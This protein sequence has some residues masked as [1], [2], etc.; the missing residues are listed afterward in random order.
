M[1][2][3]DV[4]RFKKLAIDISVTEVEDWKKGNRQYDESFRIAKKYWMAEFEKD[5]Y[6]KLFSTENIVV[7]YHA[8]FY[9]DKLNYDL[10]KSLSIYEY[11]LKNSIPVRFAKTDKSNGLDGVNSCIKLIKTKI[12]SFNDVGDAKLFRQ[13]KM[14]GQYCRDYY[15]AL[16]NNKQKSVEKNLY[17]IKNLIHEILLEN[18]QYKFFELEFNQNEQIQKII[19][20]LYYAEI[21]HNIKRSEKILID[22]LNSGSI[23]PKMAQF[24]KSQLEEIKKM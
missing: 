22:I 3:T 15:L 14:Y 7:Q 23:S 8:A 10:F 13:F 16:I 2:E 12:N 9:S 20:A 6:E 17:D 1:L 11:I 19:S 5:F 4:M 18:K 21:T 24:V